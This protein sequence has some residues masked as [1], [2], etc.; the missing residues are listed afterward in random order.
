MAVF[1]PP[2][3]RVSLMNPFIAPKEERGNRIH[4]NH[5]FDHR[6]HGCARSRLC[7]NGSEK[8]ALGSTRKAG[9]VGRSVAAKT[10]VGICGTVAV[11]V[12]TCR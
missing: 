2:S 1:A 4:L 8:G 6:D 10:V 7:D 12:V 11:I 5:L 3:G 9:V